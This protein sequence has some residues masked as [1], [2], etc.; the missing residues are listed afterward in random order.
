[1]YGLLKMYQP[2][3]WVISNNR[4][5]SPLLD[6]KPNGVSSRLSSSLSPIGGGSPLVSSAGEGGGAINHSSVD[7]ELL[8]AAQSEQVRD[9]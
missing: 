9:D 1:M 4:E 6:S 5:N 8:D 7:T 2:I 3:F